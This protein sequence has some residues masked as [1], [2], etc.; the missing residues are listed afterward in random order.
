MKKYT[1]MNGI[2]KIAYRNVQKGFNWEVGGWYNCI[3]D[4][5]PECIP[6]TEEEARED[7]YEAVL[8]NL[9]DDGY[10]GTNKA[11]KE[12][13]LAGTKFI[14]EVIDH[15]FDT[16]EDAAVIREEKW[17]PIG[18]DGK[19]MEITDKYVLKELERVDIPELDEMVKTYPYA[20]LEGRSQVQLLADEASY[21]LSM[22]TEGGTTFSDDLDRAYRILGET[23]MG[24]RVPECE[25][26]FS[27]GKREIHK[28]YK[29]SDIK[30]AKD[31][32][33][34]YRRLKAL[35]GRLEKKGIYG[36]W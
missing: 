12:M 32:V 15:L 14:K 16:D 31:T 11:P 34:E 28:K 36:R 7:V 8:K 24:T 17:M 5:C 4:G 22:Y 19:Y 10:C 23:K 35:M 25:W 20:E 33:A 13:R 21:I 26:I 27:S 18:P 9:Y 3:Q 2:E 30:W 29:E 1:E 6:D